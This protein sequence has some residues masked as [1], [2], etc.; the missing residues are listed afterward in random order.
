MIDLFPGDTFESP[1]CDEQVV[2]LD[3]VLG[4]SGQREGFGRCPGCD[5]L[6]RFRKPDAGSYVVRR[7]DRLPTVRE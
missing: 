1:C 5:Q 3:V 6:W 2:R 4:P 7:L